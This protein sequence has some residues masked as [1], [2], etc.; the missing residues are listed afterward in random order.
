MSV[1]LTDTH[2][3]LVKDVAALLCAQRSIPLRHKGR[4]PAAGG[5]QA[6][7][8]V[9][10]AGQAGSRQGRRWHVS[11]RLRA[12]TLPFPALRSPLQYPLPLGISPD[13]VAS[14]HRVPIVAQPA[15]S[16]ATGARRAAVEP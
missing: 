10:Q 11:V 16:R 14:L 13:C 2:A 4:H 8:Q 12:P 7:R 9:R 6:G 15:A 3:H 5:G 1:S